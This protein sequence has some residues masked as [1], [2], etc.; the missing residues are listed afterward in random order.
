[1]LL[2]LG[3]RIK[4][5]YSTISNKYFQPTLAAKRDSTQDDNNNPIPSGY[6]AVPPAWLEY[7]RWLP[8]PPQ[9]L[10]DNRDAYEAAMDQRDRSLH[11]I[12][13]G[14]D[15][16]P[17]FALYRLYEAIVLDRNIDMRNEIEWFWRKRDWPVRDIPDPQDTDPARYAVLA[18]IPSLIIQ[19]YNR[20]IDLG[21]PREAPG[22][23]TNEQFEEMKQRPKLFEEAPEWAIK[24]PPLDKVLKIPHRAHG[25][26][27][28]WETVDDWDDVRASVPFKMKNILIWE[29][30]IFFL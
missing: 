9:Q 19:A 24:V 7:P 21:L 6:F 13:P 28:P 15:N 4:R 30:H 26:T 2:Q 1:M 23:M 3:G 29:P 11:P 27:G 16:S 14:M 12:R 17:L 20:L 18:S 5:W 22:I 10:L 8:P 25:Y